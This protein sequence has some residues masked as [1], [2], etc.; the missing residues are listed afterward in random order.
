M[1]RARALDKHRVVRGAEWLT[2][3]G[4]HRLHRKAGL[5]LVKSTSYGE[6]HSTRYCS[7]ECLN[8]S[9]STATQALN[10]KAWRRQ[11]QLK[12]R[13]QSSRHGIW[14]F[15]G[16]VGVSE[17]YGYQFGG[18]H[19][20]DHSIFG[21]ILGSLYFWKLPCR[22]CASFY[23][24]IH[25]SSKETLKTVFLLGYS[26]LQE[27]YHLAWFNQRKNLRN[28]RVSQRGGP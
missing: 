1:P 21:S 10:L 13:C 2:R 16:H 24:G 14:C 9:S 8:V 6:I 7:L 28:V 20:K 17:N 18:R 26:L 12:P 22:F 3:V 4:E 27:E 5:L 19:N 25:L 15:E 11:C 23:S